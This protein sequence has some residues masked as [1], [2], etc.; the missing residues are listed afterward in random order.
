[1]DL[2][3]YGRV[4]WRFKFI[5]FGGLILACLL[6]VLATAK[7]TSHGLRYRK[8]V[9]WQSHS[10][11][12]LGQAKAFPEGRAILP[13]ANPDK[14]YPY[15][16]LGRFASMLE[17]YGQFANSDA[18]RRLMIREGAPPQESITA[19]PVTPVLSTTILPVLTLTGLGDSPS[20]ALDAVQRGRKAFLDYIVS[21][22]TAAAIPVKDRV[23]I[24]VL[25]AASPPS[26]LQKRKKTLPIVIFIA[27]LSAAIGLA[28]VL[29]NARPRVRSVPPADEQLP[30]GAAAAAGRRSH[31]ATS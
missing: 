1:M 27:V 25:Q 29:E 5:V 22:Q 19:A 24:Q 4:L 21:Q 14:S 11:L 20:Q 10:T 16:D 26:V 13:P 6:A 28:F 9:I 23:D 18:V 8:P 17:L 15:A 30:P 2:A 31:R 12:M 3:L 7:I